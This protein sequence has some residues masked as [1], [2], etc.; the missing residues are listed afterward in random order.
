MGQTAVLDTIFWCSQIAACLGGIG[1]MG[2]GLYEEFLAEVQ[3]VEW[4]EIQG[5][6]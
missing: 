6:A 2:F 4:D 1:L 3:Q 5:N